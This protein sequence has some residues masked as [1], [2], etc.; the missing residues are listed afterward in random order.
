MRHSQ[1]GI[2]LLLAI[3]GGGVIASQL[4]A[5][6][7]LAD[8][9][10]SDS[11]IA[12]CAVPQIVNELMASDRFTP[13]RDE[14][15][16]QLRDEITPLFDRGRAMVDELQTMQP[17]DEETQAKMRELQQLRQQHAQ[18]EQQ[19]SIRMGAFTAEQ[20]AECFTLVRSSA[21]AVAEDLGYDY[22][23]STVGED[24]ELNTSTV[25]TVLRQMLAR[26]V[27]FAP[28]DADITDD[29]REDLNLE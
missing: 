1:R 23:I 8:N 29:V 2:A 27:L 28:E 5:R 20:I 17:E 3:L 6:N 22:V 12:T 10:G 18:L 4:A 11:S 19:S 16:N 7:V 9:Q 26:P 25:E 14:L 21:G 13:A 15:A 24:E